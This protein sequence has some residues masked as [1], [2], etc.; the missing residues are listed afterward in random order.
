MKF[1]PGIGSRLVSEEDGKK[2]RELATILNE[3]GYTLRSGNAVGSDQWFAMGVENAYAQIW[4]PSKYFN[5]SFQIEYFY[6]DYRVIK[7]GQKTE[8]YFWDNH[9][10]APGNDGLRWTISTKFV[11]IYDNLRQKLHQESSH[12]REIK[13]LE[14]KIK[15]LDE[16]IEKLKSTTYKNYII[17]ECEDIYYDLDP[18]FRQL[19]DENHHLI[20]FNNGVYDLSTNTFRSGKPDDRITMTTHTD[21]H[22]YTQNKE[23]EEFFA[24][25]QPNPAKRTYLMK[26]LSSLRSW[27]S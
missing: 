4:L 14:H 11:A 21:Y 23:L 2:M 16:L 9:R 1:Y 25:I 20:G 18:K 6:H 17:S 27:V 22:P 12:V 10:W 15:K 8:W 3:M 24:Q 26:F 7:D 19:K 13:N 5:M